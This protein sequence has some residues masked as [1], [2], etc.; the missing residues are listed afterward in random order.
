MQKAV[1]AFEG[2][3][4]GKLSQSV[5]SGAEGQ[6]R[7]SA[8][9]AQGTSGT[10]P[11]P[12]NLYAIDIVF[13]VVRHKIR[14]Q[15]RGPSEKIEKTKLTQALSTQRHMLVLLSWYKLGHI[16]SKMNVTTSN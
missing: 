11:Q 3:E 1:E 15:T 2:V 8:G 12:S 9:V 14:H 13:G 7:R 5:C 10:N 4:R 6:Q 16:E